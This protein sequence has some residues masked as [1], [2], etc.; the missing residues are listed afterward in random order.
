M[1]NEA[2][3]VLFTDY[4]LLLYVRQHSLASDYRLV[5]P[6]RVV[7]IAA[8]VTTSLEAAQE[9]LASFSVLKED[10]RL[11]MR[12]R[13]DVGK[14]VVKFLT[15]VTR[16]PE[17]KRDEWDIREG[18][19]IRLTVA[20]L[21]RKAEE[22]TRTTLKRAGP[23]AM[24]EVV[25]GVSIDKEEED[26]EVARGVKEME[27]LKLSDRKLVMGPDI[28]E[29][30]RSTVLLAKDVKEGTDEIPDF[31][32]PE[33][34][35][36]PLTI[37]VPLLPRDLV[38]TKFTFSPATLPALCHSLPQHDP[39]ISAR[40]HIEE[41]QDL[42]AAD[43][44]SS[45]SP[46]LFE[47][48]PSSSPIPTFKRPRDWA[49]ETPLTPPMSI[50]KKRVIESFI[51]IA[52]L[53]LRP[54]LDTT[55]PSTPDITA[56]LPTNEDGLNKRFVLRERLDEVDGTMRVAMAEEKLAPILA[57]LRTP[58]LPLDL[59]E[60]I[61][62]PRRMKEFEAKSIISSASGVKS[63]SLDLSWK[64]FTGKV[65]YVPDDGGDGEGRI[66]EV[67]APFVGTVQEEED[68]M[69]TLYRAAESDGLDDVGGAA[70]CQEDLPEDYVMLD[71]P[72]VGD[73]VS[74]S[75]GHS[76]VSRLS[77]DHRNHSP[78]KSFSRISRPVESPMRPAPVTT[79]NGIAN[80]ATME[81]LLS[82]HM[83]RKKDTKPQE[84]TFSAVSSLQRFMVLRGKR[85]AVEVESAPVRVKH[86]GE[87]S[88]K[89]QPAPIV[90]DS[91]LEDTRAT[92]I[93][94]LETDD[95]TLSRTCWV[96]NTSLLRFSRLS[97]L[98]REL[99][100]SVRFVERD[101]EISEAADKEI[102]L[103]YEADL[104]PS[105]TCGILFITVQTLVQQRTGDGQEPGPLRRVRYCSAL[106]DNVE[107]VVGLSDKVS[108]NEAKALAAF[109][110][111]IGS[112]QAGNPHTSIKWLSAAGPE[113]QA[114]WLI[115]IARAYSSGSQDLQMQEEETAHERFLRRA[116][117]NCFSALFILSQM[118]LKQFVTITYAE[119]T[120]YF[121]KYLGHSRLQKLT[122]LMEGAV[123][124]SDAFISSNKLR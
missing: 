96:L 68:F 123:T 62:P 103:G 50:H 93:P 98:L 3:D 94:T 113:E 1:P 108:R 38:T 106:Y 32:R 23:Y 101:L 14:A 64:P 17:L 44:L 34:E 24:G 82:L 26:E 110:G 12:E 120:Q 69:D 71:V 46:S 86:P 104:T 111:W 47:A 85:D 45:A 73:M 90:Q 66:E 65:R 22:G 7:A 72:S 99:N 56:V 124:E 63:L 35:K 95:G 78:R 51:T 2:S 70:R 81:A 41:L 11:N 20:L 107:I 61:H 76:V 49:V 25:K 33:V 97:R 100:P 80:P 121:G 42:M 6:P 84:Q 116:G 55:L 91:L 31:E 57:H 28:G 58:P 115:W 83:S 48:P 37:E 40:N 43:G 74:L 9:L 119:R 118:P 92:V 30:L 29:F 109:A 5:T 89:A 75:S 117:L 105:P 16:A 27:E 59:A 87:T 79:M 77:P 112:L 122:E 4:A 10:G 60:L 18:A 67:W 15:E 13:L 88:S 54:L 52:E 36:A 102:T 39:S 8:H 19:K 21:T 114:R 53:G